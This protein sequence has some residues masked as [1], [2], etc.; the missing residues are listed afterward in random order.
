M[1]F[2]E[3]LVKNEI[4]TQDQVNK[5]LQIQTETSAETGKRKLLGDIAVDCGY[6]SK[7]KVEKAFLNFFREK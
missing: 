5:L 4:L 2:G 3:Y 1:F 7:E 6:I